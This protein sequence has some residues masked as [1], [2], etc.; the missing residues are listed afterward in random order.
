MLAVYILGGMLLTA[1]IVKRIP[2]LVSE[3]DNYHPHPECF[4]CD[5]E[6][7]V[8]CPLIEAKESKLRQNRKRRQQYV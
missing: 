6:S 1:L 7:C 8:G 3:L 5:E 2:E 4:L